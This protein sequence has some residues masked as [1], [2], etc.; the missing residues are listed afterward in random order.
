MKKAE[1][2]WKK[3]CQLFLSFDAIY[4]K[5]PQIFGSIK[6]ERVLQKKKI[7]LA[8]NNTTPFENF[9]ATFLNN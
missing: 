7:F 4:S 3:I 8:E 9:Y 6:A 1:K 2:L 5:N